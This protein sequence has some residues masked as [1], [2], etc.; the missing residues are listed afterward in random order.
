MNRAI[1]WVGAGA[2]AGCFTGVIETYVLIFAAAIPNQVFTAWNVLHLLL[3]ALVLNA[4]AFGASTA[5]TAAAMGWIPGA[6][7]H[8]GR[9]VLGLLAVLS[10]RVLIAGYIHP[11]IVPAGSGWGRHLANGLFGLAAIL[12][13]LAIW[14]GVGANEKK[15][16]RG[17]LGLSGGI[18]IVGALGTIPFPDTAPHY[19]DQ[20]LRAAKPAVTGAPNVIL[21]L[22]DT[23]RSDHLSAYGYRRPTSPVLE[24][25]AREGILFEESRS[26]ANWTI[27]SVAT[28]FTSL[29]E[30]TTGMHNVASRLPDSADTLAERLRR[31]GYTTSFFS[32]NLFVSA[33]QNYTQGFD[34]VLQLDKLW[35][36]LH[37]RNNQPPQQLYVWRTLFGISARLDRLL[38]RLNLWLEALLNE[39]GSDKP[40][41]FQMPDPGFAENRLVKADWMFRHARAYVEHLFL[42]GF[43]PKRNKLFL[44]LHYFDPH[45]PYR[46]PGPY[47]K[48]F[49]PD[50]RGRP[51]DGPPKILTGPNYWEDSKDPL[52][53]RLHRNMV[54]QYDGEIRFFD[55]WLGR[56]V[57]Y[58]KSRGLYDNSLFI[59]TSDHGE[60]FME[61]GHYKHGFT[62]HEEEI[63]V[64]L[65]MRL[66]K[67][68]TPGIRNPDIVG[69]ADVMPTILEILGIRGPGG[70][71]GK[72][73]VPLLRGGNTSRDFYGEVS[74]IFKGSY[75]FIISKGKKYIAESV[76][77][78]EENL[79]PLHF[80]K[81]RL[82]D[83][84]KDP[85]ENRNLFR[86]GDPFTTRYRMRLKAKRD[87]VLQRGRL[88]GKQRIELDPETVERLK[89]LGYIGD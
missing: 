22:V 24:E 10:A 74:G 43:D 85:R 40:G 70:M 88:T 7:R 11:M 13:F 46:P 42:R 45:D 68:I 52:P 73:L 76:L 63:R 12:L 60:A 41:L 65:V 29:H 51:V 82:F 23:L 9:A 61:H 56:W 71:Q 37:Y 8:T 19:A 62:V 3:T 18:L 4:L 44:Y 2:A 27:P 84:L 89:E 30:T 48:M 54:A 47:K 36:G 53:P 66:P 28:L 16:R 81:G 34:Y 31:Q 86:K 49:D 39:S 14:K 35:G 59:I 55:D 25:I 57:R 1:Q 33:K 26:H 38:H 50:F 69:L 72:S 87:E 6:R 83:L 78:L 21:I 17:C 15:V 80:R 5:L 77:T 64:P 75:Q 79:T 32:T 20:T 58:L 67:K